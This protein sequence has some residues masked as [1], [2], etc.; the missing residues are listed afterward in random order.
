MYCL[1]LQN[2]Q[3][4]INLFLTLPYEYMLGTCAVLARL[5]VMDLAYAVAKDFW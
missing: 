5:F 4:I 2:Y 1:S 3:Y